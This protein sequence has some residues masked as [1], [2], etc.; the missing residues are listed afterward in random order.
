MKTQYTMKKRIWTTVG[1]AL[2]VMAGHAQTD[3]RVWSI[4]L[5][6]G[7]SQYNG[8]RGNR[9][10]S[11]EANEPQYG[12]GMVSLSRY[13]SPHFDVSFFATR[14][15][16]GNTEVITSWSTPKE[17]A[18][19]HFRA[20]VN[21]THLVL[22][23]NIV[24]PQHP[25]RPYIFAGAGLLI[26]E[27]RYTVDKARVDGSVPTFGGG[28]N[29]R[30]SDFVHLQLQETFMY[31]TTDNID[32]QIAGNTNDAYLFHTVGLMFDFG[33]LP[34]ADADGISDKK[35]LCGSTPAGV[36]VDKNG[37]P[38]DRDKDGTA[39]YIDDCPDLAGAL[40]LMGCPDGDLDGI[41]DKED[42]CPNDAGSLSSRGCPDSDKDG[43]VDI[44]DKC[45]GTVAKYKVDSTGCPMDTDRDGVLNEDDRC[46]TIAGA[47]A[48]GGCADT[49]KDGVSDLDDRCPNAIGTLANK[50]CPEITKEDQMKITTIASKIY[51]ETGKTTLKTESLA[52]LDALVSILNK[53]EGAILIIEGHTDDVGT[54]EYNQELSQGRVDAVKAYLMS[55][56]IME[57]RLVSVG[58]GE[59]RPVGDNKTAAGR[60]K[61]RRVELKTTYEVPVNNANTTPEKK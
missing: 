49:D 36:E 52:Q 3:E 53:Y 22:R 29:F 51:F 26:H 31:S 59:A 12:F 9:W 1:M 6:G 38:L 35:D 45:Q 5:H 40:T 18:T 58:Y 55:K 30:L 56:G 25:V 23:Y 17:I 20:Q 16:I 48:L 13:L 8:D 47:L 60:Q 27:K 61:N 4:G 11:F 32:R 2:L 24:G 34:D 19:N 14:G 21:T 42:R 57:S 50:G 10:Y 46:P 28:V 43:I 15:Q 44:D 39:D 37:C 54:A 7:I 41:A 33:K